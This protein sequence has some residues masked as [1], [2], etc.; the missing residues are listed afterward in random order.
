MLLVG[1]LMGCPSRSGQTQAPPMQVGPGETAAQD[2]PEP[3]P[4]PTEV[5][6]VDDSAAAKDGD[7]TA[8][9]GE[10]VYLPRQS[11]PCPQGDCGDGLK[12]LT[13]YGIAGPQG[14]KFTSCEI[15]CAGRSSVCP[16]GQACVTIA[17]G[18]GQVCRPI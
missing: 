11:Q 1:L 5:E 15:P 3:P 9:K 2:A 12:C 7:A 8:P 18:P 14:P 10:T 13:Y 17:D 4:V 6:P 16:A